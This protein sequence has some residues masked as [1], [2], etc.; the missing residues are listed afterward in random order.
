MRSSS[1]GEICTP[2]AGTYWPCGPMQVPGS[3]ALAT[4]T[5]PS[6]EGN[7][8]KDISYD[9]KYGNTKGSA[10]AT[11]PFKIQSPGSQSPPSNEISY[12]PYQN[13]NW[14]Y[15][16]APPFPNPNNSNQYKPPHQFYMSNS[17]IPQ[18]AN[19]M[20]ER[21]NNSQYPYS[22]NVFDSESYS[23]TLGKVDDS[24]SKNKGMSSTMQDF[25]FQRPSSFHN[26]MP[27]E[28]F[29]NLFPVYA[30]IPFHVSETG[31]IN[32]FIVPYSCVPT[33]P[34]N[35]FESAPSYSTES[36]K[37]SMSNESTTFEENFNVH[38]MKDSMVDESE[39]PSSTSLE[40][41]PITED[42]SNIKYENLRDIKST[43]NEEIYYKHVTTNYKNIK[44]LDSINPS[45][46]NFDTPNAACNVLS[47]QEEELWNV[48]D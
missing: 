7:S 12:K 25:K 26:H 45:Y 41:H 8:L 40:H 31:T 35:L 5:N 33:A 27:P 44:N 42:D 21:G 34:N 3:L 13:D 18:Y 37:K 9:S 38:A 23:E 29:P 30:T 6:I 32:H 14:D 17:T 2:A 10:M 15:R 16:V 22:K 11:T 43:K 28:C 36:N 4:A 24:F 20:N 48:S 46:G 47:K 39:H 19:P 1:H